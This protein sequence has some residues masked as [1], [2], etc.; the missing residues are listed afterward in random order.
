[1]G[2]LPASVATAVL[3]VVAVPAQWH[4]VVKVVRIATITDGLDVVYLGRWPLAFAARWRLGK[5]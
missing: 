5:G 3:P 4:Q 1:M 2:G